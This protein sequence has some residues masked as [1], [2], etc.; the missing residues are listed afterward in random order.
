MGRA[1]YHALESA[2]N[3]GGRLHILE[4]CVARLAIRIQS[5]AHDAV[6]GAEGAG[7]PK[8]TRHRAVGGG[9]PIGNQGG[10]RQ[11]DGGAGAKLVVVSVACM[12]GT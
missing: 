8:A 10:L 9:P 5:E 7:V 2:G 11:V 3:E 12:G 1:R 4:C 6:I